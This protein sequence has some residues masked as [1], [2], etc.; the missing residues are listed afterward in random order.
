MISDKCARKI[1]KRLLNW[2]KP[3]PTFI[4]WI[5]YKLSRIKK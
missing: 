5:K 3:I 2:D 1:E 4:R